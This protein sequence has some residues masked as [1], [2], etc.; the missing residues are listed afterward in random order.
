MTVAVRY[1]SGDKI[2]VVRHG[3]AL[4]WHRSRTS[5][6]TRLPSL[7]PRQESNLD[8]PLRRL[9]RRMGGN[10]RFVGGCWGFG[11]LHRSR[12]PD[13]GRFGWVWAAESDCCPNACE[14]E[15]ELGGTC[16]FRQLG[17]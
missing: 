14:R 5:M 11:R 16:L 15:V 1:G 4:F 17:Q 7:C 9:N 3:Y 10:P 12:L 13:W 6:N 8:L 2:A